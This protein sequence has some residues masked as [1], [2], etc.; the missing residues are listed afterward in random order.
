MSLDRALHRKGRATNPFFQVLAEILRRPQQIL[1]LW[2]WKTASL[3]VILRGPIFLVAAIHRGW[4]ASLTALITECFFCAVSAGFYGALVQ[5]LR[6][7]EP[8]WPTITFLIAVVPG[9]FQALEAYLQW[10]RGTPHL[11]LA[12]SVSIA[13][14]A[15]SSL[16]N[17]YAMKRGTLLVGGEGKSFG[18]DLKRL[19][20]LLVSFVF[21]LPQRLIHLRDRRAE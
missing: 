21:L 7:A 1:F 14:S 20:K 13:L 6:D 5:E 9:I 16:F 3:S 19:P 11:W 8:A 18:S 17:W 10:I 12:E 4:R 15:V 2:N